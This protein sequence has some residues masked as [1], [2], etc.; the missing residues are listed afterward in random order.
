MSHFEI[1]RIDRVGP[2]YPATLTAY[3]GQDAP[4]RLTAIG[5]LGLLQRKKL[6]L[7]C[8]V[9]CPG[10]L[11]LETY[12]LAQ[13]L[14]HQGITVV[15]GFHSPMER[16]CLVSLLRGSQPIVVA[17][18]RSIEGMRM[19]TEF[20]QP[21]EEGRLLLLSP[22]DRDLG[23]VTAQTAAYRNRFAAALAESV[24]VS[25]AEP[26]GKM[27][28][29]CRDVIGWGKPLYTLESDANANIIA[30]GARPVSPEGVG[31]LT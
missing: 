7:F 26:G 11:I 16:E 1:A 10:K 6:A 31:D 23:R 14:R 18:A 22:F 21:L 8:S 24:F 28:G 20:R 25:Y 17:L 13:R 3:L 9:K 27:E 29:L 12:D 15:S 5:D 30:L 4:A 2:D 19:R